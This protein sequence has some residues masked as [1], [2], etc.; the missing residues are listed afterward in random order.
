MRV[1]D[2]N[3]DDSFSTVLKTDSAF[4]VAE[5]F[6]DVKSVIVL[7]GKKPVGIITAMDWVRR[8]LMQRKN[9]EKTTAGEIM[10]SPVETVRLDDD[11]RVASEIMTKN[12]Y[13]TL[14]VVDDDGRFA[15][16]I[17]IYDVAMNVREV[18]NQ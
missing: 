3:I 1:K 17:T 7:E 15:G 4:D 6:G 2:C 9:P 8:V 12:N 18:K 11:L 13:L 5:K 10:T 14:P 16:M